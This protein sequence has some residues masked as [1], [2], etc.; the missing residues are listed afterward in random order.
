M[1]AKM[2]SAP[3]ANLNQL[4]STWVMHQAVVDHADQQR[5]DDRAEHRADAPGQRGAADHRG[6]DGLQL[7][8]VAD[9]GQRR[10][11]A[12]TPG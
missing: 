11:R 3:T 7:E 10:M 4:A 8:P 6:G 1:T 2:V 9:R 12:G 5:A